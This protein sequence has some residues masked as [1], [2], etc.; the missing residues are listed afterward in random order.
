MSWNGAAMMDRLRGHRVAKRRRSR[1]AVRARPSGQSHPRSGSPVDVRDD[2]RFPDQMDLLVELLSRFFDSQR[3]EGLPFCTRTRTIQRRTVL[4]IAEE[5]NLTAESVARELA[6]MFFGESPFYVANLCGWRTQSVRRPASVLPPPPR[7][8]RGGGG[9]WRTAFALQKPPPSTSRKT[10]P[11]NFAVLGRPLEA[12]R[13]YVDLLLAHG[14]LAPRVLVADGLHVDLYGDGKSGGFAAFSGVAFFL[15]LHFI[16]CVQPQALP[17]VMPLLINTGISDKRALLTVLFHDAGLREGLARTTFPLQFNGVTNAVRIVLRLKAD[18]PGLGAMCT[19]LDPPNGRYPIVP[20]AVKPE[21]REAWRPSPHC[22]YFTKRPCPCCVASHR[23][24][25]YPWHPTFSVRHALSPLVDC[26][27]IVYGMFHAITNTVCGLL[28]DVCRYLDRCHGP[29]VAAVVLLVG[30]FRDRVRRPA[31]DV[32]LPL[33]FAAMQDMADEAERLMG[34]RWDPLVKPDKASRVSSYHWA[35]HTVVHE[36][37]RD[38]ALGRRLA[39]AIRALPGEGEVANTVWSLWRIIDVCY[40]VLPLSDDARTAIAADGRAVW[41]HWV[42]LCCFLKPAEGIQ[43][44]AGCNLRP[45]GQA[46]GPSAHCFLVHLN[47][48]LSSKYRAAFENVGEHCLKRVCDIYSMLRLG[49]RKSYNRPLL[50]LVN[51]LSMAVCSISRTHLRDTIASS[52][53]LT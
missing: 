28:A 17:A 20:A 53:R 41:A 2:D 25:Y 12:M 22:A 9:D 36:K 45:G 33:G 50:I 30:I 18:L 14:W 10:S 47:R 15:G 7:A 38:Q 43:A 39:G 5:Y 8:P 19:A 23:E 34:R 1:S 4:F 32:A 52:Y 6:Q 40:S 42:R 49:R 16:Q 24:L 31:P 46:I 13:A 11:V 21:N 44:E 35:E 48:H 3:P 29:D 27:D 37:I 51:L 26:D